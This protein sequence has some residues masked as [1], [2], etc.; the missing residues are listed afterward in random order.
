V[1]PPD[2]ARKW[3][4]NMTLLCSIGKERGVFDSRRFDEPDGFRD[5]SW[6]RSVPHAKF[7]SGC[8]DGPPEF[9]QERVIEFIEQKRCE[10]TYLPPYSLEY[11]PTEQAFSKL[12]GNLRGA[13]ARNQRR[14]V[15]IISEALIVRHCGYRTVVQTL[16]RWFVGVG[17]VG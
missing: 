13:C 7:G 15:E 1:G 4:K 9:P 17:C 3:G 12:K 14:L 2:G 6:G 10:L 16:W 5:L 8:G 11:N